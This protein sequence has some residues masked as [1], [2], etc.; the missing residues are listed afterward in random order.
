MVREYLNSEILDNN[1]SKNNDININKNNDININKNNDININKN[2]D[3]NINK[4]ND[5]NINKNN[6]ININKN[7]DINV[8]SI[9]NNTIFKWLASLN[10]VQDYRKL[11]LDQCVDEYVV[12]NFLKTDQDWKDLGVTIF[13]DRRKLADPKNRFK[14]IEGSNQLFLEEL[15]NLQRVS[16]FGEDVTKWSVD[17]VMEW[18]AT[19]QL[20]K[21]YSQLLKDNDVEGDVLVEHLKTKDDWNELGIT[22]FGDQRKLIRATQILLNRKN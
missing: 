5:T 10:L 16:K 21:N 18:V 17:E 6:D 12:E 3:I 13:G 1:I 4:N 11:F 9:S 7:N 14:S 20:K 2:N 22:A 15:I 19:L 8:D